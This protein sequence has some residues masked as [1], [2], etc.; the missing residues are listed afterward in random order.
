[1][2]SIQKRC[3]IFIWI[4]HF[5]LKERKSKTA[6]TLSVPYRKK[7]LFCTHKSFKQARNHGLI[8]KNIQK[9][10][11]FN[12][13]EWLKSY[14]KMNTKNRTEANNDFEKDFFKLINNAVFGRNYGKC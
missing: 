11:E 1:M 4:F 6:T 7:K 13:E 9:V 10:I 3:L 5:Y 14:I 8:L 12:Q 2:L